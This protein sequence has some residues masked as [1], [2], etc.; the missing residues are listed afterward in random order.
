MDEEKGDIIPSFV[1]FAYRKL[2]T[3]DVDITGLDNS[4]EIIEKVKK[5]L[6]SNRYSERDMIKIR[7]IGNV[8]ENAEV[9]ENLIAT[10]VMDDFFFVKAK[11]ESR[12]SVDFRKYALD[13]SL[14]GF[15]IR[16]VEE[17]DEIDEETKGQIVRMGL[18]AL[19][20]EEIIQ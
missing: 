17:D 14:K 13:E 11:N 8:D 3:M 15:F 1:D 18:R 5:D 2:H 10:A 19:S 6:L 16:L 4:G 9:N 7:L 12:V 20:G